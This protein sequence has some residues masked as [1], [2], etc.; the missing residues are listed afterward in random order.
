MGWASEDHPK[1]EKAKVELSKT[2][3]ALYPLNVTLVSIK[4]QEKRDILL[5]Q[6]QI[7]EE[8]LKQ[9]EYHLNR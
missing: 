6:A 4:H 2:R 8:A 5:K 1:V 7:I 9:I 3:I